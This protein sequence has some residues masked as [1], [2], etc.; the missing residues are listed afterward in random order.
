MPSQLGA[1]GCFDASDVRRPTPGLIPYDV[2]APLWSDG[3]GKRR[4]LALPDDG[5][6]AVDE[7]GDFELPLGTV[8]AKVFLQ[9]DV[10][11]ETRLFVRHA[12]GAWAGYSYRFADDGVDA[13]LVGPDAE[14]RQLGA[15][16]WQFPSRQH[17]LDCHTEAAGFSLGLELAQLD[18]SFAY[19]NG[20]T[21]NQLATFAAI[22]LFP[23][24]ER[25]GGPAALAD[26]RDPAAAIDSRARAYLHSN[27]ANCHRPGGTREPNV[28]ID[29]RFSTAL[30]ATGAC[31]ARPNRTDLGL[32]EAKLLFPGDPTLSVV[33]LRMQTLVASLRMPPVASAVVDGEGVAMID[34]WIRGLSCVE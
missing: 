12:D 30:T 20:R 1:T 7:T 23:G 14:Y 31:D 26:P 17:C 29:L 4:Y 25:P 33:S 22:G 2:I 24:G 19:P 16:E 10:P 13:Q 32:A 15:L 28:T 18:R 3:A 9:A 34:E 8:L 11:I 21:A 27:C 5:V 6:I